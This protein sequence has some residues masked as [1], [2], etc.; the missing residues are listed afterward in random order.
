MI[1]PYHVAL[2]STGHVYWWTELDKWGYLEAEARC[3]HIINLAKDLNRKW[4]FIIKNDGFGEFVEPRKAIPTVR[5]VFGMM[6]EVPNFSGVCGV[7]ASD[8]FVE[9]IAAEAIPFIL[10]RITCIVGSDENALYQKVLTELRVN[11]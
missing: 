3:K 7:V 6:L 2:D 11:V 1:S 10:P 4:A 9:V 5:R 8:M